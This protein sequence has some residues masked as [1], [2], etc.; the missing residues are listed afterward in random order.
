MADWTPTT[1]KPVDD[2]WQPTTARV[3]V[4][5]HTRKPR[6]WAR[7]AAEIGINALPVVGGT[8]GGM[9]GAA[10]GGV[11]AVPGTIAGAGLGAAARQG[12]AEL[13]GMEPTQPIIGALTGMKPGSPAS[14]VT[15]IVEEAVVYPGIGRLSEMALRGTA[16]LAGRLA[17]A[18]KSDVARTAIRNGITVTGAG[19]EKLMGLIAGAGDRALRLVRRASVGGRPWR[20]NGVDVAKE[21]EQRMLSATANVENA[22]A[23]E[24]WI[25]RRK[26]VFLQKHG[27]DM[28]AEKA[29]LMSQQANRR[30]SAIIVA[31]KGKQVLSEGNNLKA[32]WNKHLYEVLNERLAGVRQPNGG[33]WGGIPGY[34]EQN[35]ATSRLIELKDHVWPAE[36][37]SLIQRGVGAIPNYAVGASLGAA[38]GGAQGGGSLSD[39]ARYIGTGAV[40]GGLMTSPQA[41]SWLALQLANPALAASVRVAPRVAGAA[42]T[43]PQGGPPVAR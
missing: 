17:L 25:A 43:A 28:N 34:N 41:L 13:L 26:N 30:A 35:Q 2:G 27:S 33:R 32:E 7:G 6:S 14:R 12:A 9:L 10:A 31:K 5:P 8:V 3:P 15:D 18:G 20:A 42:F 23:I 11:G 40:A 29:H 1:A 22:A 38:I 39:R 36:K 19:K 37:K 21:T 4:K 16:I 24:K